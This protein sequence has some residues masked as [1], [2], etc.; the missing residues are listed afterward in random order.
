MVKRLGLLQRELKGSVR[1]ASWVKPENIH[2]TLRFLGEISPEE[3][4][5]VASALKA[6]GG[7][8]SP[9]TL[10]VGVVRGFPKANRPRILCLGIAEKGALSDLY[11]DIEQALS[12]LGVKRETRPFRAHLT[13]C[14]FRLKKGRQEAFT[15]GTGRDINVEVRVGSFE[16]LK[17]VLDPAGAVHSVLESIELNRLPG[18]E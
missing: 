15:G 4:A 6:V 2:L 3:A 17:S 1:D 14:R 7:R 16:V 11:E 18:L 5:V 10:K 9:F 12:D 8:H 13:L